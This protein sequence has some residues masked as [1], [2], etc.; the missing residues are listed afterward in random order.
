[1]TIRTRSAIPLSL[2]V[3][4]AM[5]V[6]ASTPAAAQHEGSVEPNPACYNPDYEVI[7]NQTTLGGD[8]SGRRTWHGRG[9][10][11]V[12]FWE[13]AFGQPLRITRAH[14]RQCTC[15][16]PIAPDPNEGE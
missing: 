4:L 11:I 2:A 15:H 3:P 7:D 14:V 16:G 8:D 10:V 12:N 6:F 9:Y 5:A 1:M 13:Q